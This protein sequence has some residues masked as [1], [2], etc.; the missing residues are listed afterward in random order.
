MCC[1]VALR[2]YSRV[3]QRG[4]GTCI[5][6]CRVELPGVGF[7]GRLRLGLRVG[8][9]VN[10]HALPSKAKGAAGTNVSRAISLILGAM[11]T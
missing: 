3:V 1:Y 10:H 5:D 11:V 4:V 2:R 8:L 9:K 6:S 7:G